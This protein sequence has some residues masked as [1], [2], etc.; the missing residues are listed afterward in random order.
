MPLGQLLPHPDGKRALFVGADGLLRRYDLAT[1]REIAPPDGFETALSIAPSPD[2][3]S[4]AAA[5][6]G[7][8]LDLFEPGGRLRWSAL[9]DAAAVNVHWSPDGRLLAC[10]TP[11]AITLRKP[12]T[13]KVVRILTLDD[14]TRGFGKRGRVT[15]FD[16][17]ALFTPDGGRLLLPFTVNFDLGYR[18]AVVD[19]RTGGRMGMV[20]LDGWVRLAVSPDGR[21]LAATRSDQDLTFI[22]LAGGKVVGALDERRRLVPPE[23][24]WPIAYS[25]DGSYLLTWADNG[26]AVL[27][28]P[29]TGRPVRRVKTNRAAAPGFAFSPDGLWL[30]T[31][32]VDGLVTLWD[33]GTGTQVWARGGHRGGVT[34]LGFAG[35][36]RVVSTSADL[37]GLVWDLRPAGKLKLPAWEALAG[38]DASAAYQAVW[39]IAADPAGPAL[40]RARLSP[41]ESP[42]VEQVHQWI[43]ELGA[44]RYPTRETATTAL[45]DQGRVV[46]PALRA[47]RTK[48]TDPEVRTRLDD[49]LTRLSRERT[50][51]EVVQARAVAAM[52]L[53]GTAE[54]K[55]VLTEWAGGAPGARL[56]IDAGTALRRMS[57]R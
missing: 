20:E 42:P 48:A 38:K 45:R 54:A 55:T 7:G 28:D 29:D 25:P 27:R 41:V 24:S 6:G 22:D 16:G 32:G 17:A 52:E 11:G 4:L 31:G 56:T 43:A 21:T 12:A 5:S 30:A 2:G 19:P 46:E 57:G 36:G 14:V 49:L 50:L 44:A 51:A 26:V 40:V 33:V 8:R 39:A 37:T 53:A 15:V 47:A 13:G 9:L 10:V 18:V 1:G 34:G 3:R 35:P 23:D